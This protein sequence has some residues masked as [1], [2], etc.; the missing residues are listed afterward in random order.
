MHRRIKAKHLL[1][2]TLA[3]PVEHGTT[4]LIIYR[5]QL[6]MLPDRFVVLPRELDLAAVGKLDQLPRRPRKALIG[7]LS[8]VELLRN[9]L[10]RVDVVQPPAL[11]RLPEIGEVLA[12]AQ[13][14]H[15]GLLVPL[16]GD[17]VHPGMGWEGSGHQDP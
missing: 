5:A 12:Q 17:P 2:A 7:K 4:F 13:L 15:E 9:L 16:D 10:Q 6:W 1:N 11:D 14:G 3:A 8:G